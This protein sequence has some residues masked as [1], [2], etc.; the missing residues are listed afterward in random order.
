MAGREEVALHSPTQG[1]THPAL[2]ETSGQ[3]G[4]E[5]LSVS[6]AIPQHR[7]PCLPQPLLPPDQGRYP[8]LEARQERF[9]FLL[10]KRRHRRRLVPPPPRLSARCPVPHLEPQLLSP[11]RRANSQTG[12]LPTCL[13]P[14]PGEHR[15]CWV[16][17]SQA[18]LVQCRPSRH[19]QVVSVSEVPSLWTWSPRSEQRMQEGGGP[20]TS[21]AQGICPPHFLLLL[22][23]LPSRDNNQII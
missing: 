10:T 14:R 6:R 3:A 17:L 18:L 7:A 2:K 5:E 11:A 21:H 9:C 13:T 12:H 4:P 23:P 20:L 8:W 1:T 15:V 19:L 16:Q 22:D